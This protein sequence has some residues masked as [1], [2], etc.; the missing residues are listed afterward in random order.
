MAIELTDGEVYDRIV[1]VVAR[2]ARVDPSTL[3]RDT[4]IGSLRIGS[5]D[6]VQ[7]LFEIEE[8][9]GVYFSPDDLTLRP[10]TLGQLVDDATARLA[11]HRTGG[12]GA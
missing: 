8:A 6:L 3:S 9:L 5:L 7:V 11:A 12:T 2:Y 1:S 10:T 4:P